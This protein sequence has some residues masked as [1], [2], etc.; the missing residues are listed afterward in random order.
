VK[1]TPSPEAEALACKAFFSQHTLT[2]RELAVLRQEL[3]RTTEALMALPW[4]RRLI[5]RFLLGL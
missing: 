2:Q 5:Y 1:L 3:A 4:Y